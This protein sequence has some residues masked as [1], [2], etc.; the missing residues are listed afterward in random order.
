MAA[1]PTLKAKARML[2]ARMVA[3]VC[4]K[5][6]HTSSVARPKLVTRGE[7]PLTVESTVY[8]LG[9]ATRFSTKTTSRPAIATPALPSGSRSATCAASVATVSA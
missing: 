5:V 9:P 3:A 8:Q 7:T 6:L 2:A 4:I 1:N